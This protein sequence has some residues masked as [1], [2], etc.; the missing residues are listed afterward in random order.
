MI[1]ATAGHVD[2][3]KTALVRNLT[4]IETDRLPEERRRG[5]SIDLGFAYKRLPSGHA[6]GFVDVPGHE[7]FIANM[8][9]GVSAIG[10]A[11]LVVA[12]D[13]GPMPQT[14]EHLAILDLLGVPSGVVALTK[15]DRVDSSRVRR[16]R[17]QMR[18]LLAPTFLHDAR[19]IEVSNQTGA[20]IDV[21]QEHL[22]RAAE[23]AAKRG[24]DQGYF[25]MPI[26][27][28]FTLK[29]LGLVVTG[30]VA[31]GHVQQ[32]DTL[33][34]AP[35][36]AEVHV[37]SLHAQNRPAMGASA[38]ERVA[39]NLSGPGTRC[40]RDQSWPVARGS[41]SG[42]GT[43]R[44]DAC[45]KLRDS[46]GG[47]FKH[48][49][50]VHVHLGAA[51]VPG[52]VALLGSRE[53]QPGSTALVQLVLARPV[54]AA[55]G[56]RVVIRDQS[57]RR[58]LGGAVILDPYAPARGRQREPRLRILEAL[59]ISSPRQ[60]L[61]QLL[62]LSPGGLDLDWFARIMNLPM[63]HSRTLWNRSGCVVCGQEPRLFGIQP[64]RWLL[65]KA[66][67]VAFVRQ[68]HENRPETLGPSLRDLE[69]GRGRRC[70]SGDSHDGAGRAG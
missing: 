3:G 30:A 38:G 69:G 25:R 63:S 28:C 12:A 45:M 43:A 10:Y 44:L 23:R 65:L 37:R 58:T 59:Q 18:S 54:S 40:G 24:D 48:Q 4:G 29:G 50:S 42:Q 35:G 34:V 53:L 22:T 20:G 2:H 60:R 6:L 8:L 67:L 66:K 49:A 32:G 21:L 1:V 61:E 70:L 27:R 7:R 19:L 33:I 14:L 52:R 46:E 62:A 51:D 5:M 31:S 47:G 26:D 11:I 57:A 13:D 55:H 9:A 16:V 15:I 17:E 41:R 36:G 68:W 39:L 56:D 64:D